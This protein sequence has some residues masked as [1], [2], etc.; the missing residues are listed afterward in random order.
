MFKKILISI[1]S[2]KVML[3]INRADAKECH[4]GNNSFH[5]VKDQ[6]GL[7]E[8]PLAGETLRKTVEG[9][10]EEEEGDGNDCSLVRA[11]LQEEWERVKERLR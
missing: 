4:I 3:Q 8:S 7:L 5:Q 10:A 11:A 9:C 6:P 2:S 1:F